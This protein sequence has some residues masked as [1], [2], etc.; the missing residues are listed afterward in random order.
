MIVTFAVMLLSKMGQP[1]LLYLVPFTL[2]TSAVVA[3]SRKEMRQF[4]AGTTYQVSVYRQL[5]RRL[6]EPDSRA[7]LNSQLTF[8]QAS[9]SAG[10]SGLCV[11]GCC[12]NSFFLISEC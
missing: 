5:T 11:S 4:W 6:K 1:A 8:A 12:I 2:I 3:W 9:N 7:M 10:R